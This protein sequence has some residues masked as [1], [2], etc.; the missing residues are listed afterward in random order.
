MTIRPFC[1]NNENDQ[2][3]FLIHFSNGYYSQNIDETPENVLIDFLER[4]SRSLIL[5]REDLAK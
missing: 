4:F 2:F 5:A 3:S 1:N